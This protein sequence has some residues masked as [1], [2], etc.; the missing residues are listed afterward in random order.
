MQQI[1]YHR[2]TLLRKLESVQELGFF[3]SR[4]TGELVSRLG[5]DTQ[6]VQMACSQHLTEVL[7]ALLKIVACF[8]FMFFISWK[9][10]LIIFGT[11]VVLLLFC[12]PFGAY[13]GVL[14]RRYQDV[15]GKGAN[16]STEALGAMR[17]VRAFHGEEKEG[18]RYIARIGDPALGWWPAKAPQQDETTLRVGT[19]KAF[20]MATFIPLVLLIFFGAMN[21]ILWYG[22]TLC[23]EGEI[24]IG[25]MTAYQGYI[26]NLGFAIAQAGGNLVAL[27]NARGGAARIFEIL[28][29]SPEPPQVATR[30]APSIS[31]SGGAGKGDPG[32]TSASPIVGNVS[33][34]AVNFAYPS[35]PDVNVL[36]KFTLHVPCK[37]TAAIVGASGG[38]KS[39]ALAVLS[40]FYQHSGGKV[41]IDGQDVAS[42]DI[43]FL[44]KHMTL[45]QQ[46][47]VLFGISIRDNVCYGAHEPISN[48]QVQEACK[49]A[50]AHTFI[51]DTG[52]FPEGYLT[53][54]GERG[55]RLSGGQKQRIAIARALVLQPKILLLDEATSALDSESEHLVQEAIDRVMVGRTVLVVAHRY[56]TQSPDV[57][58]RRNPHM[59]V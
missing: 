52:A 1:E 3:D 56:E 14:S 28:D 32:E 43:R 23:M 21:V 13:V 40:R 39:S 8:A 27:L 51:E 47:P 20:A 24:S 22:L 44:R 15:L 30:P 5:S 46:E 34:E 58:M 4:K 9:L 31:T 25:R 18:L 6:L 7:N 19:L 45:V 35:R 42:F 26:F 50:N 33:F 41:L 11:A 37:T 57:C 16:C 2:V 12:G 55:V 36:S 17:T 10:T 53:L 59:Y 38:G 49:Q 48:E 54:V 29:R